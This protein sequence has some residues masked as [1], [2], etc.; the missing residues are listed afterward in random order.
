MKLQATTTSSCE[1]RRVPCIGYLEYPFKSEQGKSCLENLSVIGIRNKRSDHGHHPCI[2]MDRIFKG[3]NTPVSW[4]RY[5]SLQILELA[6]FLSFTVQFYLQSRVNYT[7]K[8]M[9]KERWNSWHRRCFS[10]T[11]QLGRGLRTITHRSILLPITFPNMPKRDSV[12]GLEP[13]A[14]S[15]QRSRIGNTGAKLP[16]SICS[17][18]EVMRSMNGFIIP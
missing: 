15:V 18:S 16:L 1:L 7:V 10:Q 6:L 13:R 17:K 8:R 3:V 14:L 4:L 5:Y 11:R 2:F 9:G 12:T